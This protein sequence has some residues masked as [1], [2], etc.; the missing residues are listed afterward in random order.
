[1]MNH[2][3]YSDTFMAMGTANTIAASLEHRD[4]VRAARDEVLSLHKRLNV[5]DDKSEIAQINK[6]AGKM[7]PVSSDMYTL[8][9]DSREFEKLTEGAFK[10]STLPA[11]RMWRKAYSEKRMPTTDEIMSVQRVMQY[12]A[13][14][15]GGK[16]RYAG[17]R[18]KGQGI[19]LGG[20]AKG[21]AADS[22]AKIL[23]SYNVKHFLLN[24]GGSAVTRGI[25]AKIGIRNPFGSEQKPLLGHLHVNNCAVVTSGI[26][27]RGVEIDGKKYHHIMDPRTCRP[28]DSE[29]ASVTLVGLNA[30]EL[31]ALATAILVMGTDKGIRILQRLKIDAVLVDKAGNVCATNGLKDRL[32]VR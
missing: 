27:E 19:D 7:V 2:F 3:D 11:S 8:L 24:F 31:D 9:K 10:I 21:Y 22:A 4:A 16:G 23:G 17:L 18:K 12:E 5:F 30:E 15:F 32:E 20:I 25:D 6:N 1:M 14:R 29:L 28:S 13:V 26:Y